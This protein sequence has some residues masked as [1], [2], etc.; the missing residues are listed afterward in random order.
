MV[1]YFLLFG[2]VGLLDK[3]PVLIVVYAAA[4]LPLVVW[5]LRDYFQDLPIEIEEASLVDGSSRYGACEICGT[6]TTSIHVAELQRVYVRENGQHYLSPAAAGVYG[7]LPC[8]LERFGTLRR[9]EDFV[10]VAST[11]MVSLEQ[12]EML[13]RAVVAPVEP[14]SA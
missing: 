12:L 1:P 3:L 8:L 11:K 14:V 7:E 5:L 13:K 2:R 10:R 9:D 6:V 4:N